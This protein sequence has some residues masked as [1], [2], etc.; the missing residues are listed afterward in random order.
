MRFA[1]IAYWVV[2]ASCAVA[3]S[4]RA[5]VA[6]SKVN[7][8]GLIVDATMQG[9]GIVDLLGLELGAIEGIELVER[10]AIAHVLA[11]LKLGGSGLT[12]TATSLKIGRLLSADA[13]LLVGRAAE[14]QPASIRVRLVETQRGI[15]LLDWLATEK[16]FQADRQSLISDCRRAMQKLRIPIASRH[17]LG[18]VGIRSEEPGTR[19]D[20]LARFLSVMAENDL[21]RLPEVIVFEREQLRQLTIERDLTGVD[22]ALK[23]SS[24]L[25]EGG[26]RRDSQGDRLSVSLRLV[27]LDGKKATEISLTAENRVDS[28]RRQI[29]KAIADALHCPASDASGADSGAE[30]AA[31]RERA[32]RL[33]SHRRDEDAARLAETAFTLEPSAESYRDAIRYNLDIVQTPALPVLR[34][35]EAS[36]RNAELLRACLDMNDRGRSLLD[37]VDRR[38]DLYLRMPAQPLA[39]GE[40]K[41]FQEARRLQNE[42][43]A[44]LFESRCRRNEPVGL[45]IVLRLESEADD[46]PSPEAFMRFVQSI[47]DEVERETT[48]GRFDRPTPTRVRA[49][50]YTTLSR[51]VAR[52]SEDHTE[53]RRIR[54]DLA[55][56]EHGVFG[57]EP[58]LPLLRDMVKHHDPFLRLIGYR[59]M[60]RLQGDAGSEAAEGLLDT[61]FYEVPDECIAN[62]RQTDL[63]SMS[64]D[65]IERLGDG[66]A[67][68][69]YVDRAVNRA[70]QK[71]DATPLVR[72]PE[73]LGDCLMATTVEKACRY[74]DRIEAVLAAHPVEPRSARAVTA[75]RAQMKISLDYR[76]SRGVWAPPTVGPWASYTITPITIANHNPDYPI[77]ALAA[78]D[79][80]STTDGAEPIVL[81]WQKHGNRSYRMQQTANSTSDDASEY[82]AA[83]LRPGGGT[84]R[85]L[86]RFQLSQPRIST[87]AVAPEA[88]FFGTLKHG[89]TMIT[90]RG[91]EHFAEADGLPASSVGEMAWLD[92]RLYLALPGGLASFDP[93]TRKFDLLASSRTLKPRHELDGGDLYTIVSLLADPKRHCLWL[94]IGGNYSAGARDGIWKYVPQTNSYQHL[95]FDNIDCLTWCDDALLFALRHNLRSNRT[96]FFHLLDLD[97]CKA[98][99]LP[100]YRAGI[101]S[102]N[103]RQPGWTLI[104]GHIITASRHLFANDDKMYL[105]PG[106]MPAWSVVERL[107]PGVLVAQ[108]REA[109]LW[110]IEP[111][112]EGT[113][114]NHGSQ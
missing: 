50:Y 1:G 38:F 71:Q 55:R 80:S 63:G 74:R 25:L 68:E 73:S 24:L 102:V 33:H 23:S 43:Y 35:L 66:K 110:Y 14:I 21:Q 9:A 94:S 60:L 107:G 47:L 84:M 103:Q 6:P 109:K 44:R 49:L 7:R 54:P 90:P 28:A 62:P 98:K 4:A 78:V 2:L 15:R 105:P 51:V 97:K 100:G 77:M 101:P 11:E 89:L 86:G 22:L 106:P 52:A 79:R 19:L 83:R 96:P 91:A 36:V 48:A 39:K 76:Q 5:A 32:R 46:C 31:L 12:D 87:M 113:D 75:F 10:Q 108:E 88:M 29:A 41:F 69:A 61:L 26:I 92:N 30:A 72:W 13:L 53:L 70:E 93:R 85:E 81:V 16:D 40:Q 27:P 112:R 111:R 45:L 42:N 8:I 104:N 34:R 67:V 59:G 3:V 64:R 114:L 99:A 95:I 57:P 58:L 37:S 82:L 20:P 17:C 18:V 65:A 56:R